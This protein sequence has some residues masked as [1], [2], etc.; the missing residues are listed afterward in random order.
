MNTELKCPKCGSTNVW[1]DDCYETI[2]G[3]DETYKELMCGHCDDCGADLQWT[4]VY[5]F[6][7]FAD[8]EES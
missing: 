4:E 5:M 1:Q 3:E 7:G 6:I 2:K 8:M